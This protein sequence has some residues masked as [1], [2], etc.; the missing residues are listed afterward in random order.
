MGPT[1]KTS[2]R[3]VKTAPSRL[4]SPDSFSGEWATSAVV[5]RRWRARLIECCEKEKFDGDAD[6]ILKRWTAP[7]DS[8]WTEEINGDVLSPVVVGM[9]AGEIDSDGFFENHE[10]MGMLMAGGSPWG[11]GQW[12]GHRRRR[13]AADRQLALVRGE[14]SVPFVGASLRSMRVWWCGSIG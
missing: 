10:S 12:R 1:L 8:R 9:V 13:G 4:C 7:W 14:D 2:S 11:V 6:G 3:G 5:V